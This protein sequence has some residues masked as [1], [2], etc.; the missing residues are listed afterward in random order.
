MKN[1]HQLLKQ[2]LEVEEGDLSPES[3]HR[4]KERMVLFKVTAGAMV[5]VQCVT[6]VMVCEL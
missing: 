1:N 4:L 3:S 2:L 5:K 6:V